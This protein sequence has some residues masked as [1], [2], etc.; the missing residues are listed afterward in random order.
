MPKYQIEMGGQRYEV[1]A[2]DDQSATMAAQ[3]LAGSS[4][5]SASPDLDRIKRNVAKMASMNAPME[6]IDG[7][8]ASEGTT[9]EAVRNHP[10]GAQQTGGQR[11]MP[12]GDL[13]APDQADVGP[14]TQ[15][16]APTPTPAIGPWTQF[17]SANQSS[18]N[19]PWTRFQ[20]NGS[21]SAN[22]DVTGRLT[23]AETALRNADKAG[24]VQAATMLAQEVARLQKLQAT[25]ATA[26]TDPYRAYAQQLFQQIQAQGGDPSA[27]YAE[28]AFHGATAGFSDEL[29]AGA[30]TPL[31]MV[32]QGTWSPTEGYRYAKAQ[33]DLALEEADKKQGIFG[34]VAEGAG[35]AV[36]LGAAANAG[37]SA[38]RFVPKSL[39][40]VGR[41]AGSAVD[42]AAF[43][44]LNA[45]GNDQDVTTGAL[46]GA[47]AGVGGQV[48]GEALA[49][50]GSKV[51]GAFNRLPQAPSTAELKQLSQD[52]YAKADASGVIFAPQAF[53]RLA[54]DIQADL[55]NFGYHPA[56][57]PKAGTVL[58]EIARLAQQPVTIKGVDQLRKMAGV[59][60]SSA[61]A[62]ERAVGKQIISRIDDLVMSPQPGEILAGNSQQ[63]SDAIKAARDYWGRYRKAQSLAEALMAS[64]MRT[65]ATGS[66]GNIDNATRQRIA[67]MLLDPKTARG[68]TADEKAALEKVVKPGLMHDTLRLAGKLSPSGNGLM[69]GLG[70]GS[71]M[72]AGPAGAI[73]SAVGLSAKVASDALT[74]RNIALVDALMRSGGA[75]PS[76][77]GM[78]KL[79]D[80]GALSIARILAAQAQAEAAAK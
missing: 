7:Y 45:L 73:P 78:Q 3:Q 46:V 58:D 74:K 48:A 18:G 35:M 50:A 24:D 60:A 80:N 41:A 32:R 77:N 42:N 54:T 79:F 56:L 19:G 4:G 44:A 62:S 53:Q 11:A 31:E 15:F 39:G 8:I 27:G 1:D 72:L 65:A 26:A 20:S 29:L 5:V 52:A 14:W 12:K 9:V 57:Q 59:V 23:Q 69:A 36:P 21:G 66:G 2:P 6:D 43:G 70:L 47:A 38:A 51:A 17:Q 75:K 76:P 13:G 25:P 37:L 22:E 61:D 64:D 67:S 68:L 28:R 34:N 63:A 71:T 30:L 33:Q 55:A 49:A 10:L 16:Q 40:L